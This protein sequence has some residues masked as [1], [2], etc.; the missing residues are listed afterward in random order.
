MLKKSTLSSIE[1]KIRISNDA[2]LGIDE[3]LIWKEHQIIQLA[4]K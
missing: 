2:S 1:Y 4:I 3:L